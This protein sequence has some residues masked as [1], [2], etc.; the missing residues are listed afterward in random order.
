MR[1]VSEKEIR[2]TSPPDLA[3][4][5]NDFW[6]QAT[7]VEPAMKRPISLRVDADVLDWFRTQGP[8]YQSR[9]NAVL[10]SYM[11]QRRHAVRRKAG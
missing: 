9:M 11:T 6:D 3:D 7:V 4:L 10:R 8:R 1:R 2:A 5:P